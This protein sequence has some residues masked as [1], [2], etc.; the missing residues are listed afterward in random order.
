AHIRL[1][2]DLAERVDADPDFE[3]LAPTPFSTVCFRA[4]PA[5]LVERLRMAEPDE[6]RSIEVYLDQ[7]NEAVL[8]AVNNS[9][10]AFV[11]HTKLSGRYTIRMAIG[12]IRTTEAHVA[13]AWELLRKEA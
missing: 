3:R 11:S 5:D 8:D 1:A 4:R 9:G 12:N 13:S 10:Q 6:A 7:L 2:H